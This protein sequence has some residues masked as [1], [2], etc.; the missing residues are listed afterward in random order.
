MQFFFS[1]FAHITHQFYLSWSNTRPSPLMTW[2]VT[3]IES[4]QCRPFLAVLV[5]LFV[6]IVLQCTDA[7]VLILWQ[8]AKRLAENGM[9][10][11][12]KTA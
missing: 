2:G 4:Q 12:S 8:A 3:G 6:K 11:A 1:W 5:L 7:E 10:G 9:D